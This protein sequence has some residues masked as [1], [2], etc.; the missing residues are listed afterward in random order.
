MSRTLT[1]PPSAPSDRSELGGGGLWH[2]RSYF[3]FLGWQDFHGPGLIWP[4]FSDFWYFLHNKSKRHH[5]RGKVLKQKIQRKHY[6]RNTIFLEFFCLRDFSCKHPKKP[7]HI[8]PGPW[9]IGLERVSFKRSQNVT[10]R[11]LLGLNIFAVTEP[12]ITTLFCWMLN[13]WHQM[14]WRGLICF[15]SILNSSKMSSSAWMPHF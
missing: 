3:S 4:A 9:K 10:V 11:H 1:L 7:G 2:G 14:Y 15:S 12:T 8:W 6:S 13:V 5:C